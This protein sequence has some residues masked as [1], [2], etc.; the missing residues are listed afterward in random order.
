MHSSPLPAVDVDGLWVAYA[1][2]VAERL[3]RLEAALHDLP[4]ALD[5]LTRDAH[6]LGSSALLVGADRTA[7][8][9]R[10]LERA[11]VRGEPVPELLQELVV[12]LRAVRPSGPAAR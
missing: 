11:L 7:R 3:T 9:A 12:L 1:E 6:T 8:V 2:E 10:E 5:D 4:V